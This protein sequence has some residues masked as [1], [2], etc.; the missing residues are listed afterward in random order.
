MKKFLILSLLLLFCGTLRAGDDARHDPS[1]NAINRLPMHAAFFAYESAEKAIAGN[2]KASERY[3]SLNG[4][5][6]FLWVRDA[7]DRPDTFFRTDFDDKAW[8]TMPVPGMWQLNGY[9]DP[10]YVNHGYP[11]REQFK[12][13][14]PHYPDT[15]N[16]VGSYRRV[17]EIPETWSGQQVIA[18]FG[19]VTSNMSLWVNGR[20]VG[21]SE[22]SKLEAEFDL[23]PYVKPGANLIA[24]QI[25]RWCDGTYLEDQDFFRL[26]GIA[27]D[28]YLYTRDERHIADLQVTP[29]L[30]NGY[31][32]GQLDIRAEMSR[33]SKGCTLELEVSD[34]TG[35]PVAS[36]RTKVSATR[37]QIRLNAGKVDLWSAETPVLYRLTATLRAPSGEVIEVIPLRTGFREVK[38]AGGQLLVNGRPI[39]VKGVNRHEMDPDGGY[40]VSE[41]RMLQD[42]RILK[43]NNFNA[44]RTCHYPDDVRWYELCD[45]YGLYVVAEAN[46][47]SHGMGYGKNPL[48][49]DPVWKKAHLE[50]NERNVRRN[51]NHPSVIIWSLGNESGDGANFTACYDWIKAYDPSRPVQFEQAF[52]GKDHN[53]DIICPMYWYYDKC[54]RYASDNPKKP[55]IQCEYA[56]AMG[57]S[58]GG[59]KEYWDLIRKYPSYQGGFI[60]DF[61]D[62]SLRK[63]GKN[64]VMIYGY[65]GDWNPYDASDKNFC[66]NGLV[67]PDRIPNPHMHEVRYWQQPIWVR[68]VDLQTGRIAVFNEYAFRDISA[69]SLHWRLL[70]DGHEVLCG[71]V[72]SLDVAPQ[73]EVPLQ[74]AYD[75]GSLPTEGELLLDI[76][77]RLQNA[78]APLPAGH[79]VARQQLVVRERKAEMP[80]IA[81]RRIDSYTSD[82]TVALVQEDRN[83][84]IVEGENIRLDFDRRNGFMTRYEVDGVAY[85]YPGTTLRPNFWRA[86]TDNDFGA[87]VQ[88]KNRMWNNPRIELKEL[89][90]RMEGEIAVITADYELPEIPAKLQM[91]YR[92]GNTGEILVTEKLITAKD[93]KVPDLQ[94]F[95]MRMEMPATFDRI[96]YYGRGPWENYSDRKSSAFLGLYSQTVDEQF[97]PYIRPQ[98]TGTKS[99]IRWWHQGDRSGRGLMFTSAEPFSASALHYSQESLDEGLTKKQGH[100]Q[101]VVPQDRVFLCIDKAQSGLGC[102]NSWG[103]RPG[104]AYRLPYKDYVFE[105]RMAPEIKLY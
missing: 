74:L 40:I 3:L 47:E 14:P 59:F 37:Q 39:L 82:G 97:Y 103:A 20:Y 92:V 43:E 61:V 54:K 45:E 102:V 15:G 12:S 26:S 94:R 1:I 81:V 73:T 104:A 28:C 42:I 22:D 66:D 85:L 36:E 34:H 41:E 21:Y 101:E 67:S 87:G 89:V 17:I 75:A 33:S 76:A 7:C 55:L 18:H 84:L 56:H 58:M 32:T 13:D 2:R 72:P 10:Q 19:S 48:A 93:V 79:T 51:F 80:E 69:Y 70:C 30:D 49:S 68:E 105:F 44:V 5:W 71:S 60:W 64:G 96:N 25:F 57:N 11:W 38:I 9:G 90:G 23:T 100:S 46:I 27:R 31:T 95:G 91:E 88:R 4:T 65:G 53:T 52:W 99:D 78:E 98:E 29:S 86:P 62:Q 83:F 63:Q 24:F 77:F 16:H 8:K 6:K 50:R 35:R